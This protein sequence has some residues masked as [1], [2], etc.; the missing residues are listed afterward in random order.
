MDPSLLEQL[1]TQLYQIQE[2]AD[3]WKAKE[4]TAKQNCEEMARL[5]KQNA[6]ALDSK[7]I[8]DV[9]GTLFST[10]K[11]TLLRVEDSYFTSMLLSGNWKPQKD[12]TYFIDRSPKCF[13]LILDYM[14]YGVLDTDGL[15]PKLKQML[16]IDF[17]Y[18][19]PNSKVDGKTVVD[20]PTNLYSG[21]LDT[22]KVWLGNP[23]FDTKLLWR[24][25]TDGFTANAFHKHCDNQGATLT[26]IKSS[27]DCIFGGYNPSSWTS[28]NS[29]S[30]CSN[31]FVFT[32][33]NPNGIPP[34]QYFCNG[35]EY[36]AYNGQTDG[37]YFGMGG[38]LV[39]KF[40]GER[41]Y[42]QFPQSYEDTTGFGKTTFTGQSEFKVA[43]IEVFAM[44]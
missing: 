6:D 30:I 23:S 33:T 20:I 24:G 44:I 1:H 43:E 27:N 15:M 25:S 14:R 38:D 41:S 22:L 9:S 40:G 39:V 32:L 17:D 7:I 35:H 3:M 8:F 21:Y 13:G 29:W 4:E 19:F 31:S 36:A 10:T 18:F 12:G 2:Q 34:T 16:Q 28:R 26:I 11:D 42:T 5:A 37:P